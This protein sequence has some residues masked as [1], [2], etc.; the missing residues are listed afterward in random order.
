MLQYRTSTMPTCGCGMGVAHN[1]C[2]EPLA[3]TVR[4]PMNVAVPG[5]VTKCELK[6]RPHY[7]GLQVGCHLQNAK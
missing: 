7:R 4:I 1:P 5:T 2:P 3:S 6:V